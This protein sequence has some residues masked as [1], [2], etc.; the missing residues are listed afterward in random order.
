M[1]AAMWCGVWTGFLSELLVL[2]QPLSME[3][4][5]RWEGG[6]LLVIGPTG[7]LIEGA[8]WLAS[9]AA[10]NWEKFF[11][12]GTSRAPEESADEPIF[13]HMYFVSS[14]LLSKYDE[15]IGNSPL[16]LMAL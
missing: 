5:Q 11:L 6:C 8:D 16:A 12:G 2:Q 7:M 3:Q 15:G 13:E 10:S 9:T 1:T 14:R 4:R